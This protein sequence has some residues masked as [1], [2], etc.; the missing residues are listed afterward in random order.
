MTTHKI[1]ILFVISASRKRLDGKSILYCRITYNKK[2]KQFST[3]LFINP[4]HWNSKQQKVEPPNVE[5]DLINTQLSLIKNNIHQAFL[6]LQIGAKPFDVD[7]IYLQYKGEN[8]KT[9]K[10]L[11]EVFKMHNKFMLSLVGTGYSKATYSKF[12]EAKKHVQNFVKTTYKK[13]DFWDQI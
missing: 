4:K 11:L 8:I 1:K 7:D 13:N 12:I 3:G 10:T 2:R 9:E 6:M 5:H